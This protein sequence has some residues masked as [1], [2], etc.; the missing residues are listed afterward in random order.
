MNGIVSKMYLPNKSLTSFAEKIRY[1]RFKK[2]L[3]QL[4]FSK[5]LHKGFGT[6]TKWEQGITYPKKE[7]LIEISKILKVDYTYFLD[8]E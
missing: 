4:Q 1:I 6:I 3:T 8:Q 7:T 5:L 2:G